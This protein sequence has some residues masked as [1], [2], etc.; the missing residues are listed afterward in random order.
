M[1]THAVCRGVFK[2]RLIGFTSLKPRTECGTMFR[3]KFEVRH[4]PNTSFQRTRV[5]GGRGLGPLN[6]KR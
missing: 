2:F 4:A 5:R 6:S 3:F 1:N